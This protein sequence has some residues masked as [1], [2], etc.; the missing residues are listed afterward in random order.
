MVHIVPKIAE[1]RID[2]REPVIHFP[3]P[4]LSMITVSRLVGVTHG[5][6]TIHYECQPVFEPV[7][8]TRQRFGELSDHQLNKRVLRNHPAFIKHEPGLHVGHA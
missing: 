7:R 8:R 4:D 1:Q 3:L 6:L 5:T 2:R